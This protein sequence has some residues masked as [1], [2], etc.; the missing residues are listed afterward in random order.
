MKEY[1]FELPLFADAP[2]CV[3]VNDSKFS[4]GHHS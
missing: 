4:G 1:A 2:L 3:D